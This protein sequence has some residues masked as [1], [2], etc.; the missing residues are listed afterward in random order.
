MIVRLPQQHIAEQSFDEDKYA[1]ATAQVRIAGYSYLVFRILFPKDP[2]I[3]WNTKTESRLFTKEDGRYTDIHLTTDSLLEWGNER[4]FR[5]VVRQD[6]V[7][8][9]FELKEH[10]L[11]FF[12]T[13]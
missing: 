3:S 1:G 13:I 11:L 7:E 10:L 6:M 5:L 12:Y 8:S 4:K 2:I 9:I